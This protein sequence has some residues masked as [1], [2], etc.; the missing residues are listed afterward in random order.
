MFARHL[1]LLC[2]GAACWGP[3]AICA[4]NAGKPDFDRDIQPL[5][6]DKCGKCHGATVHKAD[7][8]LSS[9]AGVRAGGESGEPLLASQLDESLLWQL[10]ESREMPP[11]GESELDEREIELLRRWIETAGPMSEIDATGSAGLT[12]HDV[13]PIVLLRC[14]TCHGARLQSGGL[15]LRTHRGMLAGGKSGP[16][17]VPGNPDASLMIRRIESGECPPSELLL[18]FFVRRPASSEVQRLRDW[19]GAGAPRGDVQPDV[20]TTQRDPL[21]SDADR[22]HWAFQP[23]QRPVVGRCIDDFIQAKLREVDLELSP[24]ADRDT[25][26]RRVYLD[27]IGM[28]QSL[29]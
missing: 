11:S 2:F 27:L 14:T 5:L 12:E 13:L 20:A 22:Q 16:A 17:M 10:V 28:P 18:K 21:V 15:D 26:I 25:L 9:R 19:I 24:P 23:P 29:E 1:L 3:V 4:A 7:L 8:D 6:M